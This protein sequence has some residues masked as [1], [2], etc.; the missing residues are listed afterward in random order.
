MPKD[1]DFLAGSPRRSCFW[2]VTNADDDVWFLNTIT[3]FEKALGIDTTSP[4]LHLPPPSSNSTYH[5]PK[6]VV[7]LLLPTTRRRGASPHG[8][9]RTSRT[10]GA[11]QAA[12]SGTHGN[13]RRRLCGDHYCQRQPVLGLHQHPH[14]NVPTLWLQL[15]QA[16]AGLVRRRNRRD[17]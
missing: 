7:A 15:L 9:G 1:A 10:L 16:A 2:H 17:L 11:A 4:L 13:A 6:H 12:R 5:P 8:H 14:R 3:V